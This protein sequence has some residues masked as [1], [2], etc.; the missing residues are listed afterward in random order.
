[1]ASVEERKTQLLGVTASLGTPKF[2]ARAAT[3]ASGSAHTALRA[4]ANR[5][6]HFFVAARHV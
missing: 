2:E 1:M 4:R 5:R 6:R 3:K